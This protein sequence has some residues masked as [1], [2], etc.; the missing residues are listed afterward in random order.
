MK[1]MGKTGLTS[2]RSFLTATAALVAAVSLKVGDADAAD[3]I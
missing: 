2:R 3:K 1:T